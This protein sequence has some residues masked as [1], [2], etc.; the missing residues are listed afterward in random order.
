MSKTPNGETYSS[1]GPGRPEKPDTKLPASAEKII[2]RI[3]D[4]AKPADTSKR[5]TGKSR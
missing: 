2:R 3:F 1:R 4:N 5:Q